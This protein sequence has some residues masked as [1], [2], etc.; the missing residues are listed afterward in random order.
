MRHTGIIVTYMYDLL[1][2]TMVGISRHC[3]LGETEDR[4]AEVVAFAEEVYGRHTVPFVSVLSVCAT[5]L[6]RHPERSRLPRLWAREA[7][8]T[9]PDVLPDFSLEYPY[10]FSV[11]IHGIQR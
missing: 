4:F 11:F 6:H 5:V 2:F 7:R 3:T 10:I 9:A 8:E 1:F